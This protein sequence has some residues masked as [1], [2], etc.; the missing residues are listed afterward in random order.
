MDTLNRLLLKADLGMQ[1]VFEN[2][3]KYCGILSMTL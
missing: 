1:R 2:L 3:G